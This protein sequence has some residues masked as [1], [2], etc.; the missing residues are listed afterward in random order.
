VEAEVRAG[1][2]GRKEEQ[3]SVILDLIILGVV[4]L[5]GAGTVSELVEVRTR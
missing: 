5:W 4:L 2:P 3:S 1:L